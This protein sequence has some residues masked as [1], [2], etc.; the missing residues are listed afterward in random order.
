MA[1]R[2]KIGFGSIKNGTCIDGQWTKKE[3]YDRLEQLIKAFLG[4]KKK[5][6]I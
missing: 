5:K 6:V 4:P 2:G 1:D 3:A